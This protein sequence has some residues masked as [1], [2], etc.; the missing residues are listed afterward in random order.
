MYPVADLE[1]PIGRLGG[2][3]WADAEG[4]GG[5]V[6]STDHALTHRAPTSG[7]FLTS[8]LAKMKELD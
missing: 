7:T 8:L 5:V 6:G 3:G 2:M 4:L 1:F